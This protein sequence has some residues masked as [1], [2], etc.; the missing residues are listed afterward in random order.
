[1]SVELGHLLRWRRKGLSAFFFFR[2]AAIVQLVLSTGTKA[3]LLWITGKPRD[4][5]APPARGKIMPPRGKSL[6]NPSAS[7][8]AS[9]R[10]RICIPSRDAEN[11]AT[12]AE[13]WRWVDAPAL[14]GDEP[15]GVSEFVKIFQLEVEEMMSSYSIP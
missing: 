13:I 4:T 11:A 8:V 12:E 10:V 7:S 9:L 6:C 15:L 1:M 2:G 14:L 5:S 3:V